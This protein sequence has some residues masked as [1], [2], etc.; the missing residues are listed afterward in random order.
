[1]AQSVGAVALDIVMGKNTVSG[2]AKQA[3]QEVQK[4]FNDSAA[5]IGN[6]ASAVGTAC[7]SIG[8]SFA[9][10]SLGAQAMIKSTADAAMS[11]ETAMAQVET[12][13]GN[14]SVSYQGKMMDM[15]NAIMQLSTDTGIAAEDV[16]VATYGAISAGV[17]VSKSVEFVATANALAVG[18]FTD[19]ATSVDVLTTTLNAYGDKAGTAES[20]S[21][22]LITTQNLGKTTVNEL[23]SSMGK[24]IPAASAYGVSVDNLCASYVAMTKGGI[25]TA[26]STTYMKSML[27][28]LAKSSSNVGQI[29]QEKTGKSFGQLMQSGYSLADVIDI[30]GQS[31]D[32]DSE[33]FA[34]LWG[35]T[36]AG[37][38]A[39]AIL[40]GGTAD[41]NNTL[42][43][44]Q[45]STGAAASAM[46]K[47]N[48]T[49]AHKM[50][51]AMNDMKN[52]AIELG[53]AF[54]PVLSGIASVVG[55]VA[56]A[57]NSLPAPVKTVIAVILG[58]IA[59][60]SPLL[61]AIGS[62]I[63]L[64]GQIAPVLGLAKGA[65]ASINAVMLANPIGLVIAAIAALVAGFIYLWNNCEGFRNFWINLW[66]NIKSVVSTAIENVKGFL[67]GV[68][69]FISSNWQSLLTLLVNP[70]GGAF[71]LIYNNCDG[72]RAFI[73]G[74]IEGI[75][76]VVSNMW[77]SI[78]GFFQSAW[79]T[80]SGVMQSIWNTIVNIWNSI[81]ETVRPLLEAFKYL[82]DTIFQAIFIIAQSIWTSITQT[83]VNIW[84]SFVALITPILETIKT[85]FDAAWNAIKTVITTVLNAIMSVVTTVWNAIKEAV[86]TVVNA[87]MSV[88]TSVWNTIKSVVTTVMNAIKSVVTTVWN[89]IKSVITSVLNSVK[90]FVS[91]AMNTIRSSVVN[92]WSSMSSAVSSGVNRIYSII[93]GGF[94]KAVS[95]IK[96]LVSQ[97]FSWGSDMMDGLARGITSGI[98]KLANAVNGAAN[99]I[100]SKLHFSRPD[101]GPLRDYET[102]MP[103]F[104]QGMANG[105][106]QNKYKLV[107]AVKGMAGEMTLPAMTAPALKNV[108]ANGGNVGT[109]SASADG[110]D[111]LYSLLT[112]LVNNM[113]G[114]GDITIPVYL[115]NDLI[116]EQVIRAS[117]RRTLR[118]GGRA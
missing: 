27:N 34:Q 65:I 109:G 117:D 39:L 9:P 97:A 73:D 22:K 21:D 67:S 37:T 18:G 55:G 84:N 102:W 80:I 49:S 14:A 25:A 53:G 101:E 77:N 52:A 89:A 43:E 24:V 23:A 59:V 2:V 32:G 5:T 69:D 79:N 6:K 33:K 57:F 103:D 107:N 4:T 114:M 28:E 81:V 54:A 30:L 7:K 72:F 44:M 83:I 68:V 98:S 16:A 106:E 91:S 116:D 88:V 3:I 45:N 42:K 12:I 113:Q 96:N 82:F 99:K 41:F 62:V 19:M 75:K 11:F 105:I 58:V 93:Q 15:S 63:T 26:E 46:D 74:F 20:I 95:F 87:I 112:Q 66:E 100:R 50:Q 48:D 56:R 40:N 70:I 104:V 92:I 76:T 78:V 108:G 38:G 47:M 31:V 71:E 94:N 85:V 60:I 1:M 90:S 36:E 29:L 8:A 110:S 17:D 10:V 35:S 118:S 86:T 64:V 13:A 115:G 51:V 61:I 111:K